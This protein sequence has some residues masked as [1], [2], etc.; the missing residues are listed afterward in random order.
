MSKKLGEPESP[1]E[2]KARV[3]AYV[4]A[5]EA[6]AHCYENGSRGD[7]SHGDYYDILHALR[8]ARD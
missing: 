5:A 3:L 8:E 4:V 6:I 2:T 1:I 7:R